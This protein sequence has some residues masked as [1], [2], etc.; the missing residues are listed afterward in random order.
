MFPSPDTRI[1]TSDIQYIH[2][3]DSQ[4]KNMMVKHLPWIW[5]TKNLQNFAVIGTGMRMF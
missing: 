3:Y 4:L 5:E 1:A 2:Y